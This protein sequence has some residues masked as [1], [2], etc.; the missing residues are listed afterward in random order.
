MRI[1]TGVQIAIF[2]VALAAGIYA[3]ATVAEGWAGWLVFG[4]FVLAAV[5]T[6]IAVNNPRFQP[7]GKKR[8]ITRDSS[9]R[10]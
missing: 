6:A 1:S 9:S 7:Q 5:G 2:I 4:V 3:V 10:W 8:S